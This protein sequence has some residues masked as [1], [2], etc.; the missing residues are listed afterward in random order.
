[1]V[2]ELATEP[3]NMSDYRAVQPA[4]FTETQL[5]NDQPR[6]LV[7]PDLYPNNQSKPQLHRP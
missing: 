2:K 5:R 7:L 4:E 6:W 1:M 3:T